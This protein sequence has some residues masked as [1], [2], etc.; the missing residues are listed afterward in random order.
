MKITEISVK[1]PAAITMVI[2]LFIGLGIIGYKNMGAD[3]LPSMNIP[4]ITV[5]TTYS[6][7]S[8]EDVKKIL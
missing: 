6:G 2:L 8:A 3:L 7:A 1:K 5:S 4:I